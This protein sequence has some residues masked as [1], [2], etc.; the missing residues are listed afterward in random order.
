[1]W[2][3]PKKYFKWTEPKAFRLAKSAVDSANLRWR[4]KPFASVLYAC[5]LVAVWGLAKFDPNKQPPPA[6][7]AI[8]LALPAGFFTVYFL[9]WLYSFAPTYVAV[10]DEHLL[11]SVANRHLRLK[12]QDVVGFT[13]QDCGEFRVLVLNVHNNKE[14]LVG[15]PVK[16]DQL[17][18]DEFLRLRCGAGRGESN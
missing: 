6:N 3:F 17:A 16:I 1:M 10:F 15:V 2:P 8:G 9:S 4:H 12:F 18:L 7:L 13:F 14:V 5:G 11:R